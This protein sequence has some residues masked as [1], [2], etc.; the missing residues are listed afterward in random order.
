MNENNTSINSDNNY[1]ESLPDFYKKIKFEYRK[2]AIKLLRYLTIISIILIIHFSIIFPIFLIPEEGVSVS[3][4]TPYR[5]NLTINWSVF[6]IGVFLSFYLIKIG[7]LRITPFLK[8]FII[9]EINSLGFDIQ[10]KR[11]SWVIFLI[12]NSIS[13]I[14]LFLTE[15][16]FIVFTNPN[17]YSL[18]QGIL[19]VWLSISIFVPIFW[20]FF[21]DGLIIDL[22]GKYRVSINAYYKLKKIK[23]Y[24]SQ[25]IGIFLS[26]S[27]IGFKLNKKSKTIYSHI[28]EIRWLPR[29]RNSIISKYGLSPFLR[30]YEFSTPINFQKQFL[31]IVLALQDYVQK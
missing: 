14:L 28:A 16:N 12:L 6:T 25:L 20:R 11:K 2:I 5:F 7:F 8:K 13:M 18:F 24:D 17:F 23:E 31:N 19:I 21:Y 26:S 27:K 9:N 1:I 4:L 22:K 30:F 3:G 15:L 10:E 29:K